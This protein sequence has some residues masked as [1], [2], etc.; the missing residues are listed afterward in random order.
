ME[1]QKNDLTKSQDIENMSELLK[2]QMNA[3]DQ[4]NNS[5]SNGD[6]YHEKYPNSPF[7]LRKYADSGWFATLGR[8]R[9]TEEET[10]KEALIERLE[11]K[12]WDLL[13][14]CMSATVDETITMKVELAKVPQ[15]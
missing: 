14:T 1:E 8:H 9:I 11:K 15:G 3:A 2:S 10:T 7:Y 13:L 5:N 6:A 4:E 12:D